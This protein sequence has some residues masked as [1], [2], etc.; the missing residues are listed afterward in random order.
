MEIIL[1]LFGTFNEWGFKIHLAQKSFW[2]LEK[3]PKH[4]R[5]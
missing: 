2:N 4:P 3:K 5:G 1:I